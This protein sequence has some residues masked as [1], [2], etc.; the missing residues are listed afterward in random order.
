MYESLLSL[1][2]E[3]ALHAF[4]SSADLLLLAHESWQGVKL[5]LRARAVFMN[6]ATFFKCSSND[7]SWRYPPAQSSANK[8]RLFQLFSRTHRYDV[9]VMLDVDILVVQNPLPFVGVVKP[10]VLYVGAE[11]GTHA[12]FNARQYSTLEQQRMRELGLRTFNAGLFI[13]RPSP[14]MQS[15]LEEAY[16]SFCLHPHA[17]LYEQGHLNTV[18]LTQGKLS[19]RLTHLVGLNA[20]RIPFS[21]V[22]NYALLHAYGPWQLM[23]RLFV[24][25]THRRM[26]LN[27]PAPTGVYHPILSAILNAMYPEFK[28][29][30]PVPPARAAYNKAVTTPGIQRVCEIGAQGLYTAAAALFYNPDVSVVLFVE[31]RS[32][33]DA[34]A[35]KE[36]VLRF[37][38][39]GRLV[40]VIDPI[41]L[42]L[43]RHARTQRCD[44][45]SSWARHGDLQEEFRWW[46]AATPAF[47]FLAELS[48][49]ERQQW[50]ALVDS[51]V[52][53]GS[54]CAPGNMANVAHRGPD[55]CFGRFHRNRHHARMRRPLQHGEVVSEKK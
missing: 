43:V 52:I 42:S 10:N 7:T 4:G 9:V 36:L 16:K 6:N 1:M 44:L 11:S 50:Q 26:L 49:S 46:A 3:S 51:Q 48:T 25:R 20:V 40:Y 15:L 18:F 30:D 33:K 39:R 41:H 35:Y 55:Y 2:V 21:N 22:R 23:E 45:I 54:R 19:Y 34:K 29:S 53:N 14:V 24:L 47:A 38:D 8:L 32:A 28:A 5:P 17:S 13:F 12:V 31:R 37:P 27:S